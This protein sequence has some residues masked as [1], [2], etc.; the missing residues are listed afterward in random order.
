MK[1]IGDRVRANKHGAVDSELRRAL[2]FMRDRVV[3]GPPRV[4]RAHD[5][6]PVHIY[7]DA[8]FEPG[9]FSGL[10]GVILVDSATPDKYFSAQCTPSIL[11]KLGVANS[12]NPI[13]ILEALAV[14][15][16]LEVFKQEARG[17]DVIVFLDND[18]ALGS[19][20][21]CKS[22]IAEAGQIL[23]FLTET[24]ESIFLSLWYERVSSEANIAD[25]PSR[26]D[27][28]S[29]SM[30]TRVQVNLEAL[31]QDIAKGSNKAAPSW[32]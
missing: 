26:N 16:A 32:Q 17:R 2:E 4:V 20:I 6:V 18:G 19:F 1:T 12:E 25:G 30:A 10:G 9:G 28:S 3:L 14:V 29:L 7:T 22:S 31:V 8:S 5:P 27:S 13:Y 24:L 15:V 23:E 11:E 21:A